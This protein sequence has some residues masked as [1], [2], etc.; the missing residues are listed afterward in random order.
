MVGI[1][2]GYPNGGFPVQG[3]YGMNGVGAYAAQAPTNPVA[4]AQVF[5]TSHIAIL[6]AILVLTVGGYMLYHYSA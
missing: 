4:Q 2:G 6:G 3:F 5:G 1:R